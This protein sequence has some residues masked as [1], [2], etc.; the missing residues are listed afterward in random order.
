MTRFDS[1]QRP[2]NYLRV[3]VTDR[4]NLRCRWCDTPYALESISGG[5][6]ME[7]SEILDK[8]AELGC[9]FVEFTGGEP[10]EQVVN[11]SLVQTVG[12]SV[13]DFSKLSTHVPQGEY[14]TPVA[15][16]WDSMSLADKIMVLDHGEKIA[17]GTPEEIKKDPRVISAYLGGQK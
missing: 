7:A 13:T 3:S 10:L 4:C 17:E 9:K 5:T 12:R 11:H 6:I 2:I 8:V 1:Y 15:R 16:P 14:E